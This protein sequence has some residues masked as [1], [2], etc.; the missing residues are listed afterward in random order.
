MSNSVINDVLGLKKL[1][2]RVQVDLV[3]C[4]WSTLDPSK[5]WYGAPLIRNSKRIR[6]CHVSYHLL[7]RISRSFTSLRLLTLTVWE[8]G[9]AY[10]HTHVQKTLNLVLV[11][12]IT[13]RKEMKA[14]RAWV[15]IRF[16]G[17]SPF[18]TMPLDTLKPSVSEGDV[19]KVNL[20]SVSVFLFVLT[21]TTSQFLIKCWLCFHSDFL[22]FSLDD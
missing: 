21:N 14:T 11:L 18:S 1:E 6:L 5:L 7:D 10:N 3:R 8:G 12:M 17:S 15:T 20:R 22:L 4:P 13:R 9:W 2:A 16:P 19:N